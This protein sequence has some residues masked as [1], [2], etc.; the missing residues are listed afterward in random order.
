MARPQLNHLS[1]PAQ[2]C[3]AQGTTTD[4]KIHSVLDASSAQAH[5]SRGAMRDESV[6]RFSGGGTLAF[7]DAATTTTVSAETTSFTVA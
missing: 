6:M 2:V 3:Q 5:T 4:N 1:F 7:L